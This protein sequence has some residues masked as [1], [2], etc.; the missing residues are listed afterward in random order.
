MIA[1]TFFDRKPIFPSSSQQTSLMSINPFATLEKSGEIDVVTS[2]DR[3]R[4]G[5]LYSW[6]D[7]WDGFGS[8]APNHNSL[9]HA[10]AKLEVVP[11]I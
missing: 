8:V 3:Q 5:R 9:A 7:N 11:Q 6:Q 4:L 2:S 1:T 10:T